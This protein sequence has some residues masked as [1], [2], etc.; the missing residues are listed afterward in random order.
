M[1]ACLPAPGPSGA[2]ASL[3]AVASVSSLVYPASLVQETGQPVDGEW[4]MPAA[5]TVVDDA[6]FVADTG[7]DRVLKLDHSGRVLATFDAAVVV[8]PALREPMAIASDGNRLFVANSLAAEV[9]VLDLS[10]RVEK[11]LP[12]QPATAGGS[13]P[14][15]IGVAVTP[16]GGLVV[17][18][19]NNNRVVRLDS[20]G[21]IVWTAGSGRR[22]GGPDGFNVPAGMAVD[23]AG[24]VYVVDTLNGRVV[25]LSTEGV[26]LSEFAERGSTA[27]TLSRPKGVV[28][29]AE[30]RVYVSDGMLASVQVFAADGTYLGFIGRR[31]PADPMSA[32]IFQAPAGLSLVGDQLLVMDR[33]AGLI[34]LLLPDGLSAEGTALDGE[35]G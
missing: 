13:V 7:N 30:G 28:V 23:G 3:G 1:G 24:N 12:L 5:V 14:R 25:K 15:P 27:G 2:T 22:A 26:Y 29:D 10:G 8:G 17:S 18:D 6:T 11:V 35:G 4:M 33:F 16:D 19:A 31:N 21:R 32:S 20:E 34:T 9:L